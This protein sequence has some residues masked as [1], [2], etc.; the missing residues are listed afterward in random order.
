MTWTNIRAIAQKI[1]FPEADLQYLKDSREL[2]NDHPLFP[3]K[4]EIKREIL[5]EY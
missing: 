2:H 5:T 1:V 4:I 3:D